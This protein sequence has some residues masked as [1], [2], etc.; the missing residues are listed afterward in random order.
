MMLMM[1]LFVGVVESS[2]GEPEVTEELVVPQRNRPWKYIPQFSDEEC[3]L[4]RVEDRKEEDRGREDIEDEGGSTGDGLLQYYR[5]NR[6]LETAVDDSPDLD[7]DMNGDLEIVQLAQVVYG[8]PPPSG[9]QSS[10]DH[11]VHE[12]PIVPV[13]IERRSQMVAPWPEEEDRPRGN[14]L[15]SGGPWGN[16]E[17]LEEPLVE[18]V[19]Q[20]QWR[21]FSSGAP[22]S[23]Q[24]HRLSEEE[25]LPEAAMAPPSNFADFP[26]N[27]MLH[28]FP[29][30]HETEKDAALW[31]EI[32]VQVAESMATAAILS[33]GSESEAVGGDVGI[34]VEPKLFG[35]TLESDVFAPLEC[36]VD[37]QLFVDN[38]WPLSSAEAEKDDG[39][40]QKTREEVVE[41]PIVEAKV[42]SQTCGVPVFSQ[43]SQGPSEPEVELRGEGEQSEAPAGDRLII[44]S[45]TEVH[46]PGQLSVGSTQE[47]PRSEET[48]G[49]SKEP[50][51]QGGTLP[52]SGSKKPEKVPRSRRSRSESFFGFLRKKSK[53]KELDDEKEEGGSGKGKQP[54]GGKEEGGSTDVSK[55]SSAKT[56]PTI[57]RS[58]DDTT[59]SEVKVKKSKSHSGPSFFE[60]L[61][62]GRTSKQSEKAEKQNTG[63]ASEKKREAAEEGNKKE[64]GEE[65]K[66]PP[67]TQKQSSAGSKTNIRIFEILAK[68][69]DGEQESVEVTEA[70]SNYPAS[71]HHQE[72]AGRE[73]LTDTAAGF[74]STSHDQTDPRLVQRPGAETTHPDDYLL[75]GGTLK[76]SSV[77]ETGASLGTMDVRR[78]F[79]VAVAIDFGQCHSQPSNWKGNV[80]GVA[81]VISFNSM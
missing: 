18:E 79:I 10:S 3:R 78:K 48:R 1:S 11:E 35:V 57:S 58:K 45:R 52:P 33:S 74:E 47:P 56:T 41:E 13:R 59:R 2:A 25:G 80:K 20:L 81:N 16:E 62:F 44:E 22:V 55:A 43:G 9:G 51:H 49:R 70:G 8:R 17:A 54:E 27:D 14:G 7:E 66:A 71:A 34:E 61:G 38:T 4:L 15:T 53:S 75:V 12:D 77:A 64:E 37:R 29:Q 68:N 72:K 19:E 23:Y 6:A 65:V 36:T 31:D 26:P 5:H 67:A 32:N 30:S 24:E 28:D 73:V 21:S 40:I 60:K 69:Q 46:Q 63:G 76:S 42:V 39:A 50:R